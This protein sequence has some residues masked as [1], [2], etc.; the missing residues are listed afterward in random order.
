LRR[1]PEALHVLVPILAEGE[2]HSGKER[3]MT[4]GRDRRRVP[5]NELTGRCDPDSLPFE[6]TDDLVPLD[7]IF[8]QER[9]VRAIEFAL[10]M[11][12]TGYNLYA[13]GPDG[14]GKSTIVRNIL[15]RNAATMP[16][17]PD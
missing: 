15:E 14:F 2:C 17:P 11:D 16:P 8:G 3:V 5:A 1:G 7:A 9:A 10:G 13:A 6:T 12:A 4:E